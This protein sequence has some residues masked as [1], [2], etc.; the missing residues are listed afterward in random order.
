MTALEPQP[1]SSLTAAELAA[2]YRAG[3]FSPVDAINAVLRRLD[4]VNPSINAVVSVDREGAL[5]AAEESALRWRAGRPLSSIDGVPISVKDNLH[6]AGMRATWGSRLLEYFVPDADEPPIAKLRAAGSIL[7]AKTN[8]PEFT[9][10]GYTSN[11][12]FGTTFNPHAPGM[13]PG[14]STGGGAAAVAAG[15]GPIAIGTDGGGSIRR[16]AAHC[17]LFALKPSIGSVARYGG[18]PQIL[19]D[20][21]VIGILARTANDL[22]SV[23]SIVE[24][25]DARD[26]RSP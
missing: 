15:L 3:K 2:A 14:G 20:F 25:P 17:G 5:R 26:P 9:L 8:V 22:E 10:Q 11:A 13:T 12:I 4:E 23:M 6:V 21:E 1:L 7:F 16:P 24:V 19:S 18:F